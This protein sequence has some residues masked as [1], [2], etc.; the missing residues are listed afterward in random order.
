MSDFTIQL[1]TPQAQA[2]LEV[3]GQIISKGLGQELG[4]DKIVIEEAS[5]APAKKKRAS[6]KG[7]GPSAK[8]IITDQPKKIVRRRKVPLSSDKALHELGSD[9]NLPT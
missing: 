9:T 7:K 2:L 6:R 8:A 4:A 3:V 5:Q 1:S